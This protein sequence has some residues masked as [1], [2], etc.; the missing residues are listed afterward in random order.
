MNTTQNENQNVLLFRNTMR[1]TDGHLD[2][3][4][5][6]IAEAVQFAEENAP[7][8]MV[9]VF[10]D[11]VNMVAHSIQLYRDTDAVRLHWKL[12]DPYIRAVME[13]CTVQT[14]ELFG[15]PDDDV[16]QE[17]RTSLGDTLSGDLAPR[18]TGFL[19]PGQNGNPRD[20]I[21]HPESKGS[22]S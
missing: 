9:E 7:Q 15:Q 17:L 11:E 16:L 4:K 6:A 8:L 12:S 19:R 20:T 18:F 10:L 21:F 5:K 2:D 22:P 14:F 3:F 13:H 1:I